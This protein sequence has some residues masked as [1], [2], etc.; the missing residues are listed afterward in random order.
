MFLDDDEICGA[1]PE[2]GFTGGT[3]PDLKPEFIQYTDEGCE[4]AAACL[5]CPFENCLY[6]E[7]EG[8]RRGFKKFRDKEIK[9]LHDSGWKYADLAHLFKV[10]ERTIF[11]VI[12]K[13]TGGPDTAEKE[14]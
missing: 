1:D 13:K 5:E 6:D 9:R 2:D 4:F 11:R 10:S 7:P 3:Q 14:R 8:R 12:D